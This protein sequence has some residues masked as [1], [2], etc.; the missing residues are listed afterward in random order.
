M[1][2]AEINLDMLDGGP[3]ER[4]PGAERFCA[5]T[6][7]VRPVAEMIRFVVT[8]DGRVTADLRHRLPGRGLWITAT[9]QALT[10][11]IARKVFARGF[12][13]EVGASTD[14]IDATERL[15]ETSALAALGV[16]HKAGQVAVGYAKVAAALAHG[17]VVALVHAAE[18]AP[19]GV[20]KLTAVARRRAGAKDAQVPIIDVFCSTQLDLALGRS[21]VIHAAV[22]GGRES[23]TFRARVERLGHFRTGVLGDRNGTQR[24]PKPG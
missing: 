5:A 21:N 22:L 13:R 10:A 7:S 6:G 24:A 1:M 12:R 17:E 18:A 14:L 19:D 2:P 20:G 4:K 8:P 9:R 11:A 3:R 23:E 15:M 16:A